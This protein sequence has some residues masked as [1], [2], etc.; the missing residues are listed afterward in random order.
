MA[1]QPCASVEKQTGLVGIIDHRMN[2]YRAIESLITVFHQSFHFLFVELEQWW[3]QL[4]LYTSSAEIQRLSHSTPMTRNEPQKI[5]MVTEHFKSIII[6]VII[7]IHSF[8]SCDVELHVCKKIT[9]SPENMF[10]LKIIQKCKKHFLAIKI[11]L[12]P[13]TSQ[14]LCFC[15]FRN[16]FRHLLQRQEKQ[17]NK[18]NTK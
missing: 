11:L 18:G 10:F 9:N 2:S 6:T 14:H 17:W 15:H 5:V 4:K 13:F 16:S 12:V 7:I 1:S 3:S 8:I